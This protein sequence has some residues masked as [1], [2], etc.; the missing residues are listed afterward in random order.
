MRRKKK[1][2]DWKGYLER[3]VRRFKKEVAIDMHKVHLLCLIALGLRQNEELNDLTLSGQLLSAMPAHL[4]TVVSDWGSSG[5]ERRVE[6]LLIWYKKSLSLEHVKICSNIKLVPASDMGKYVSEGKIT[7]ARIWVLVFICILRTIGLSVR[8]V[9]SLHAIPFKGSKEQENPGTSEIKQQKVKKDSSKSQPKKSKVC[10]S[11]SSSKSSTSSKPTQAKNKSQASKPKTEST[12][13]ESSGKRKSLSRASS[14]AARKKMKEVEDS[15]DSDGELSEKEEKRKKKPVE[16]KS[17]TLDD[18]IKDA[19]LPESDSDFED[20]SPY[21][22]SPSHLRKNMKILSNRKVL[23]PSSSDGEEM[24]TINRST[25][26]GHDFWMEIY[27]P[28]KKKW[29]CFDCFKCQFGKPYSLE[30][31]A[32]SPLTYVVAFKNDGSVKDVTA[33]YAKLWM[34]HTRKQRVDQDWW[35]ETLGFFSSTPHEEDMLE[36]DEIKG[37]LL[38][39]PMP[40]SI[41]DFKSHPL[42]ALRRHLLKFEA[43]YPDSSIPLGY[44]KQEPIYARECVHTLHSRDNWLKEG[45]LVR[46]AEQPYKM[47]K[48]RPK[49]N[50]PKANPDELDLELYGEWQTEKYIPPPAVNG[51]VPKNEYGNLEIFKPWMLPL[52]TVQLKVNG[53]QRVA[54]KLGIDVAPAMVGW[55]HHSGRSHPLIDGV[56]VCEEYADT[57]MAAWTEDQEIQEQRETEKR[58]KRVYSNWRLLIRGLLI[59]MRLTQKFSQDAG[60]AIDKKEN[61]LKRVEELKKKEEQETFEAAES[62][63]DVQQAWPRRQQDEV[64]ALKDKKARLKIEAEQSLLKKGVR[65]GKEEMDNEEF[66]KVVE[67]KNINNKSQTGK[68]LLERVK[69]AG[70]GGGRGKGINTQTSVRKGQRRPQSKIEKR[71]G[72]G[73]SSEESTDSEEDKMDDDVDGDKLNSNAKGTVPKISR[74]KRKSIAAVKYFGSDEEDDDFVDDSDK[75]CDFDV[76]TEKKGKAKEKLMSKKSLRKSW[77]SD[78]G[79]SSNEDGDNINMIE[80]KKVLN[81]FS[82]ASPGE[83]KAD[84]SRHWLDEDG[85]SSDES[86]DFVPVE[87]LETPVTDLC[88]AENETAAAA[89]L[90]GNDDEAGL[91]EKEQGK[92]NDGDPNKTFV[93][94]SETSSFEE[95]SEETEIRTKRK[96]NGKLAQVSV[97]KG[98]KDLTESNMKS[99]RSNRREKIGEEEVKMQTNVKEEQEKEIKVHTGKKKNMEQEGKVHTGKKGENVEEECEGP[100]DKKEENVENMGRDFTSK[101]KNVKERSRVSAG[102]KEKNTEKERE[103]HT[104]IKEKSVEKEGNV[105][106]GRKKTSLEDEVKVCPD[107]NL[108]AQTSASMEKKVR[109]QTRTTNKKNLDCSSTG[110]ALDSKSNTATRS[111]RLGRKTK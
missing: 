110:S 5:L 95:G 103:V 52:G 105:R 14:D 42:Y 56:V 80:M 20:K 4:A 108:E 57:L 18:S 88:S 21:F 74:P 7:D 90:P 23:S 50:K 55:D 37:Q 46:L 75:D 25:I 28:E 12:K 43:I 36:D 100:T 34:S 73:T 31:S 72:E 91:C 96:R 1:E 99:M 40:T 83:T 109:T 60:S 79:S 22:P 92:D 26:A 53:L 82:E 59:K 70:T 66:V 68:G 45:R 81:K 16:K 61:F 8:L 86:D 78:E 35:E 87:P 76:A 84:S 64:K 62:A 30:N 51:K 13:N 27:F 19:D 107:T 102:K 39:R 63:T 44:I 89:Q 33:R 71:E 65:R 38:V 54:K 9:L 3:R 97:H 94:K 48:S 77:L 11:T 6:G 85:S 58:E 67:R 93:I 41:A 101:K 111:R 106:T 17:K 49:W 24:A 32:T 10:P 29:I 15:S 2:F 104:G 69:Q 98:T 47:V